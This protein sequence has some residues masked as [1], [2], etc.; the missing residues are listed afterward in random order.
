MLT[1]ND[2]QAMHLVQVAQDGDYAAI[3]KLYQR[4]N[5]LVFRTAVLLLGD[6]A[7][8]EEAAQDV[9]E[10][11]A[12]RVRTYQPARGAFTAWLYQVTIN[13]C[14]GVYRRTRL[15][16]WLSLDRVLRSGFDISDGAPSPLQQ[17]LRDEA[18][19]QV[20]EAIQ[21]L[22]FKLRAVVVLR[23]YHNFSYAETA[24]VLR[25]PIGA[26]RSRLLAAHDR[27]RNDLDEV[28]NVLPTD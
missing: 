1:D 9:F 3:I 25:C 17:L 14:R 16:A 18:H 5:L 27:L 20:W 15:R 24:Q 10:Q 2:S 28:Y 7:H 11:F 26:V 22:P 6:H 19:R 8:A 23:Y 13:M 4:Y 21:R 12:Q